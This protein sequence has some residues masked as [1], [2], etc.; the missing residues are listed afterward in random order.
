MSLEAIKQL[1]LY[2]WGQIWKQLLFYL[3]L[4]M[5]RKCIYKYSKQNTPDTSEERGCDQLIICDTLTQWQQQTEKI[6][7]HKKARA[8]QQSRQLIN[9]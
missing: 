6:G 1:L 8:S 3:D 9:K 7:I 2:I 4:N 5:S